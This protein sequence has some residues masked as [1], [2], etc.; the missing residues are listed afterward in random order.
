MALEEHHTIVRTRT[1]ASHR[2]VL[3]FIKLL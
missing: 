1:L 3:A 2:D